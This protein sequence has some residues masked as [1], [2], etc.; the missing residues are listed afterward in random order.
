M[1]PT[2][3]LAIALLPLIASLLA[4][5]AGKWIGRAGAAIA[6]IAAVTASCLLSLF[7]LKQLVLDQVPNFDATVYSWLVTDGVHMQVGFL[8][9]RLSALMMVVVTFVS[10]CVHIYTVGYMDD[11]PGYQRFFAY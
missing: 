3:L 9:D 10:L 5:L 2:L 1:N 4:G 11:D 8:V 7:V 6:T